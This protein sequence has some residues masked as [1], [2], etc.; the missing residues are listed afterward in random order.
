MSDLLDV[1]V[2]DHWWQTETGSPVAANPRGLDVLPIKPGSPTVPMPGYGLRVL[3]D[4]GRPV[5]AGAMGNIVIDMPLPP[6]AA[7]TL[8]QADER[9]RDSYLTARPGFYDTADAGMLDEDGYVWVMGRT[10]DVVNVAGHR[11]STGAIEEAVA[12]HPSVAEC[13]V[14]GV[15][16][17]LKGEVPVGL[18]VLKAGADNGPVEEE[19]VGSVRER[20]GPV[21]AFRR[22]I[23]VDRLPKTRS[24][25]I[26]RATMKKMAAG[27]PYTV[28]GTI[29]DPAVLGEIE[30]VLAG[31]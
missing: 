28:P 17:E 1:P 27:E 21:A 10:D 5:E 29:E 4:E 19:I 14:F 18:V 9:F 3:D 6:G 13:A 26:L 16:D 2:V 24:G 12:A 22:V 15:A 20:I 23:V 31:R 11:L 7:V 30:R 8:W 25:K